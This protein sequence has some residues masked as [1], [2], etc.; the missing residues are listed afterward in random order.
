MMHSTGTWIHI[1]SKYPGTCQI[2]GFPVERYD[3][4]Y[5]N[6]NTRNIRHEKCHHLRYKTVKKS[7]KKQFVNQMEMLVS[8]KKNIWKSYNL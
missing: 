1:E 5:W 7:T 3:M 2:C 8:N 4:I 6:N